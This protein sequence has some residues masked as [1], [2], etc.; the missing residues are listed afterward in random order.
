M[1]ADVQITLRGVSS[2]LSLESPMTVRRCLD[3]VGTPRRNREV[4][5]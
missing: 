5:Q 2:M 1:C 4:C 3:A